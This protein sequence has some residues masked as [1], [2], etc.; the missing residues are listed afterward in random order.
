VNIKEF[1]SKLNRAIKNFSREMGYHPTHVFMDKEDLQ[2]FVGQ[3]GDLHDEDININDLKEITLWNC[4]LFSKDD[5]RDVLDM[6]PSSSKSFLIFEEWELVGIKEIIEAKI[7]KNIDKRKYIWRYRVR[8][9]NNVGKKALIL[10]G[11]HKNPLVDIMTFVKEYESYSYI[12]LRFKWLYKDWKLG[13]KYREYVRM[14]MQKAKDGDL[15]GDNDRD[16]GL[17]SE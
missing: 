9:P 1:K 2:D 6:Y 16:N 4:R 5:Y 7:D 15:F 17:L 13:F 3:F 10:L 14:L 8:L 11:Q 12:D